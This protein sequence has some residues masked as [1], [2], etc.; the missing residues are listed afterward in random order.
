LKPRGS[1]RREL[2]RSA[3]ATAAAAWL[4]GC[5]AAGAPTYPRPY[6]R[7]PWVAPRVSMD[8]VIRVVVGH[9]PY[10]P[11][12]F[13]VRS[14]RIDDALLVHNY[15]HGGAGITLS[16]GSSALAV[17]EVA[18]R[19]PGAAAVIGSGVMGLTTARLL[20]DA[21]WSV[22]IYTADPFRHTVSSVAG[23]EW[24][25]YSVH[26]PAMSSDAFKAQ[27]DR[28]ARIAHHAFASL[29]PAYGVRWMELY[30]LS[31]APFDRPGPFDE[32]YPHTVDLAAGTHPFPSP[33][34]RASLTMMIEPGIFLREL[35]ADFQCAGGRAVSR[36]FADRGEVLSLSERVVFNCTGLGAAAL[37]GDDELVPAK[38][39]LVFLPPDPA[40]DYLTIGGGSDSL[41]MFS[42]SDVLLLGGTFGLGDWSLHA[43]PQQ[44][45]R[46]VR[47]HQRVFSSFG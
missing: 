26:D 30:R 45:E 38:G 17:R 2:L 32:F 22:T 13:V 43:D 1:S 34:V 7:Q 8:G 20:Q 24:G 40:V 41:Y 9:R 15:G 10:R 39:Q 4:G 33:Y 23:G 16:W 29:G 28:A 27:L 5:A 46:I 21:G 18:G 35:T 6:S 12:G 11:S 37:F 25:P 19:P 3:A 31:P 44:T 14:E 36:R 42:R 47:E